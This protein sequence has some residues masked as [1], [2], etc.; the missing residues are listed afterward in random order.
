M[1]PEV[2]GRLVGLPMPLVLLTWGALVATGVVEPEWLG[3]KTPWRLFWDFAIVA[4]LIGG[5]LSAFFAF[6]VPA[7]CPRCRRHAARMR[8]EATIRYTCSKCGWVHDTGI[9]PSDGNSFEGPGP[10]IP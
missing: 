2:H 1:K 5:A 8:L 7:S 9:E 3:S 4:F 10:Y 6:V